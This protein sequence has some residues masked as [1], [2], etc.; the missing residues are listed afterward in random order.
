MTIFDYQLYTSIYPDCYH[1][2][3]QE[4]YDNYCINSNRIA[5]FTDKDLDHILNFDWKRYNNVYKLNLDCK[6]KTYIHWK[7]HPNNILFIKKW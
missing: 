1:L 2:N 7:E 3:Y 6:I 5:Y 4:A